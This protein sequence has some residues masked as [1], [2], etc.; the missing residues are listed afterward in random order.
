MAPRPDAVRV[1]GSL[2]GS[3]PGIT[4][5]RID[6]RARVVRMAAAA[7]TGGIRRRFVAAAGIP[8]ADAFSIS[9]VRELWTLLCS[10]EHIALRDAFKSP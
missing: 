5:G 3:Q 9:T 8:D 1:L 7:R 4:P 2:R 10:H 6:D